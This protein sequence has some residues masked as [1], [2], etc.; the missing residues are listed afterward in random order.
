MGSTDVF[1]CEIIVN[2]MCVCL[3]QVFYKLDYKEWQLCSAEG[4]DPNCSNKY[5]LD[6]NVGK[7]WFV[8]SVWP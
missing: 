6:A 2:H 7:S 4:E 5:Y 3:L 8:F 1:M